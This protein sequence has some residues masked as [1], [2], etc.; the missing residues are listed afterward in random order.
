MKMSGALPQH[1]GGVAAGPAPAAGQRHLGVVPTGGRPIHPVYRR[2]TCT[3]FSV[4]SASAVR[5]TARSGSLPS[6]F[7]VKHQWYRR[8]GQSFPFL[9]NQHH[10]QPHRS[11]SAK[12]SAAG[13]GMG[14]AVSAGHPAWL[15]LRGGSP[16]NP[17]PQ[18]AQRARGSSKRAGPG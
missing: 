5:F 4:Q 18:W 6:H 16:T 12:H 1:G 13:M 7:R 17:V 2:V 8:H 11:L 3:S 10:T 15:S 14:Q 9:E